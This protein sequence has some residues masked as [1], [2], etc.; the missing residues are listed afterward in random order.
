MGLQKQT[1]RTNLHIRTGN[2]SGG[3]QHCNHSS[4]PPPFQTLT[5]NEIKY[6]IM[7][8][9]EYFKSLKGLRGR[10][11][12]PKIREL[13]AIKKLVDLLTVQGWVDV[14]LHTEKSVY[15][16]D[17]MEFYTNM[18]IL[19]NSIVSSSVQGIGIVFD[20]QKLREILNVPCVGLAKY[21]W[22]KEN[23]CA[24]TTKF[25]QGRVKSRSRKVLKGEMS[26]FHKLV[27]FCIRVFFLGEN[28]GMRLRFVIWVL[29][30]L[31]I[32]WIPLT[33]LLL[34]LLTWQELSIL[35]G[36]ISWILVTCCLKY[37]GVFECN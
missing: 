21:T 14:F 29:Q 26:P 9:E 25:A 24:L 5:K 19:D 8:K 34:S 16:R 11:I 2:H 35:N 23:N 3:N 15:D 36:I 33:G 7:G 6:L 18:K 31:W 17:V 4:K 32:I 28:E 20:K 10:T 13:S 1:Q 37:L 12:H 22:T 27:F 30:M